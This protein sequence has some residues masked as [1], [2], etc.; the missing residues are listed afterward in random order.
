ME[1]SGANARQPTSGSA[2][3]V[4]SYN[5][6]AERY[7]DE[8]FANPYGAYI[9]AQ[10]RRLLQHWLA[11][12]AHGT[13]LDLACGTG[14]L[15]D[16]ATHGL[17]ASE[18]MVRIAREKH[19]RKEVHC[20][21]AADLARFRIHFDGIFCLHLLMH[22]TRSDIDALFRVCH[23]RL[24]PGGLFAF[25]VPSALRRKLT[26]F[27]PEGW[28]G[29]TAFAHREV[30]SLTANKWRFKV[31]RGI[32]FFPIH[33]LPLRIRP[34]LRRWDDLIGMTPLKRVSSYMLFCVE[35]RP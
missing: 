8:R 19:P 10:E 2:Q 22:L 1:S 6:L 30:T 35:K 32:L 17:D 13:I 28:H 7:D 31:S 4:E 23:E 33:R 34:M 14:R 27:R 16:M 25:D 20:G 21:P 24:R 5:Q 11:P 9:H 18:A 15:L 12:I 29:G 26:G 3:L